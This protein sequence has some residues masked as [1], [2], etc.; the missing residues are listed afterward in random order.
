MRVP[1]RLTVCLPAPTLIG[2]ATSGTN[3]GAAASPQA[4][5][6]TTVTRILVFIRGSLH[7]YGAC[8]AIRRT[9][10][11]RG[12][13]TPPFNHGVPYGEADTL[14][15]RALALVGHALDARG[16]RRALRHQAAEPEQGRQ[17]EARLSRRQSDGQGACAQARRRGH[18]RV[19]RDL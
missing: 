18:H 12:Y 11:I 4:S 10:M 14:P 8:C 13:G 7:G 16:N 19:R 5:I 15:R 2:S 9:D 3:T 17:S 6:P 1:P